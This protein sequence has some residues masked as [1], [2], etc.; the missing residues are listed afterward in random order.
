MTLTDVADSGAYTVEITVDNDTATSESTTVTITKATPTVKISADQ[1]SLTGSGTVELTV[2]SNGVPTEGEIAVTCDN[3]ITVTA[4]KDGPF[5]AALPNET[6]TYTFTASYAGDDNHKE[7]ADTCKVSVTRR[8][9]DGGSSSSGSSSSGNEVSVPSKASNG[10][11]TVSP[12]NA[13]KGDRVTITVKP[14]SGY[15]LKDLTVTDKDGNK[16][17][18]TDK[19]DGKYTFTMP[20]GKVDVKAAFAE[21]A[22]APDF[23]D[24]AE[25]QWY[26]KAVDYVADKGIM[27]GIGGQ[28][29]G[30]DGKLT[31]A[32]LMTMLARL[33]GADTTGGSTWY[34]QGRAWAME[35]G[36]SDGTD[37]EGVITREQLVVMLYRYA[38]LKG[39]DVSV[40]E[41]TD[42]LRYA[43][44]Q[45]VSGWAMSAMRWACGAGVIKGTSDVTLSP[46]GSASRAEVAAMF[47]NYLENVAK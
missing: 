43:D 17:A 27:S 34:E 47:M 16:I 8:S 33:D 23:T 45:S 9:S 1:T 10:A 32:M 42:I 12:K 36:V 25:G 4:N 44:A 14:D 39:I 19:G 30:P 13:S 37:P 40:G 18:L 31:R 28:K 15:Q 6:K 26:A 35:K 20:A 2:I 22:K 38:Q 5:S 41:D 46:H 24:V 11:V 21:A 29:F 7:A 3:G